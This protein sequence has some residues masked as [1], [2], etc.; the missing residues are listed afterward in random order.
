MSKEAADLAQAQ[1][2]ET[3]EQADSAAVAADLAQAVKD[4]PVTP[5]PPPPAVSGFYRFQKAIVW[6]EDDI[7][8]AAGGFNIANPN[9]Q[10]GITRDALDSGVS[11][12][13][14]GYARW[15]GSNKPADLTYV[16][17]KFAAQNTKL[18]YC[19]NYGK[20]A[21]DEPG[22]INMLKPLAEAA[23]AAGVHDWE[24]GSE[25]NVS[26]YWNTAGPGV[27]VTAGGVANLAAAC[28]SYMTRLHDAYTTI[29]PIDPLANI[30]MAGI[31][32][33]PSYTGWDE[34][35][36]AVWYQQA[37]LAKYAAE[38]FCDGM[39]GHPYV[40]GGPAAVLAGLAQMRSQIT[41]PLAAK[42]F[43]VTEIGLWANGYTPGT[44]NG[45]IG[46]N[47]ETARAA[48]YAVLMNGMRAAGIM[49]PVFWYTL[50]DALQP[51]GYGFNHYV[52][53]TTRTQLPIFAAALAYAA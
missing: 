44:Q 52:D 31:S 22:F 53:Y 25:V 1:L 38:Q 27:P 14:S 23:V 5:P 36:S 30:L 4:Q 2:D 49:S 33:D 47:S 26:T 10:A 7:A 48:D 37:C 21:S 19:L 45:Y 29:K 12:L 24:V 41:G 34:I 43:V 3:R 42:P 8:K 13:G 32:L 50:H 9:V 6:Q 16:A 40:D 35:T 18:L 39:A 28:D 20:D 15:W 46:S 11:G 51:A 17:G